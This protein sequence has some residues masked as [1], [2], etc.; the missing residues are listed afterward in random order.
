[1]VYG[2][3]V[4]NLSVWC[5]AEG[6]VSGLR[7]AALLKQQPS[8]RTHNNT[9]ELLMMGIVVPETC[10]SSNKICN[11]N[12][13][14]HLVGILFPQKKMCQKFTLSGCFLKCFLH[15]ILLISWSAPPPRT[16]LRIC[17]LSIHYTGQI[18]YCNLKSKRIFNYF[19]A[20]WNF[21]RIW[22][23]K[24]YTTPL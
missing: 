2:A 21:F 12:H 6:Y 5:G 18:V 19:Y 20:Q 23:E 14:L 1:V 22:K 4:F 24:C 3:L 11:K 7:A 13:L 16:K 17:R 15:S 9:L 8:N 10:W